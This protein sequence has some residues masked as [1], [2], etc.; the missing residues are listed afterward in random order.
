[1]P[2]TGESVSS[3]SSNV[4][5]RDSNS[6]RDIL[7]PCATSAAGT[8]ASSTLK[9]AC[10]A[11]DWNELLDLALTEIRWYGAGTPQV[12]RRLAAL[13]DGLESSA[14]PDRRAAITRHRR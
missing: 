6:A 10:S 1:M 11:P 8:P 4:D 7:N 9:I 13:L 3:L 12:T 14:T 5:R 2:L